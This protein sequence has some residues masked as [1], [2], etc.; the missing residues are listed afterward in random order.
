MQTPDNYAALE[1]YESAQERMER[2]HR[3]QEIEEEIEPEDL[4]FYEEVV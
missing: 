4:P 3:R 1:A 2:R